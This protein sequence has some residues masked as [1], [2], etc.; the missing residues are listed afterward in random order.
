[1]GDADLGSVLNKWLLPIR[2]L[3]RKYQ[4]HLDTLPCND[5]KANRLAELNV[6]HSL[7]SLKKNATVVTAMRE[8][9]LTLHGVIYD[10]PAGELRTLDEVEVE[11][12]VGV[13]RHNTST[14]VLNR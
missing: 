11:I 14:P 9:G 4:L 13:D 7:E 3:R 6:H 10:I 2:E 8:W 12:E 5:T 1:M